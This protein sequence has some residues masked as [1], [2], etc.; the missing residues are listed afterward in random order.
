[1][2][3]MK[4]PCVMSRFFGV[5]VPAKSTSNRN[6]PPF[7]AKQ[8]V[9]KRALDLLL[10][11][12]A[13]VLLSP[14]LALICLGIKLEGRSPSILLQRRAAFTAREFDFY[15][16]TTTAWEASCVGQARRN[17]SRVTRV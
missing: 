8:M 5:N 9:A 11:G 7:T 13:L 3:L 1:M 10:A 14:I 4:A 15:N 17:D 12:T 6:R 2:E 16:F